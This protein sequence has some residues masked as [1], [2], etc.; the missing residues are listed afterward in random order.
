MK[1][2]PS[3]KRWLELDKFYADRSKHD[4]SSCYCRECQTERQRNY[5]HQ[6]YLLHRG[7]LLPKHRE[8]ALRSYY[9]RKDEYKK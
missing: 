6:Y 2:C 8:S 4:G 9:K 5:L 1:Q 3:C 7:V